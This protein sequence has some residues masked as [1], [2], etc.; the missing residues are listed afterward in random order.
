MVSHSLWVR[1]FA[2]DPG[3]IGQTVRFNGAPLRVIGVTEEGFHGHAV[4]VQF[5]VFIPVGADVPGVHGA[6]AL[7]YH[8]NGQLEVIARLAPGATLAQASAA[9]DARSDQYVQAIEGP[10]ATY[11]LRMIPYG[12]VPG[13]V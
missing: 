6:A 13:S 9:A 4:A 1:R 10:E 5:D 12:G 2:A 11:P 3:L 7:D 8:R